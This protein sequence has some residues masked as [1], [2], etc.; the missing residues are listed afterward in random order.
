MWYNVD[1]KK[2]KIVPNQGVPIIEKA[3]N[4]EELFKRLPKYRPMQ[5][6]GTPGVRL[7]AENVKEI[8]EIKEENI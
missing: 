2:Y 4:L 1:M 6:W 5:T 8:I 3:E 7:T